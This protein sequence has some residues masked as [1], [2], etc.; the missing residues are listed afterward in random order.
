MIVHADYIGG[1]ISTKTNKPYSWIYSVSDVTSSGGFGKRVENIYYEGWLNN[2]Q[3]PCDLDIEFDRRGQA[4]SVKLV[5]DS[6]AP[7]GAKNK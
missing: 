4:V 6:S 5:S 7:V 2:I 1:G 3:A